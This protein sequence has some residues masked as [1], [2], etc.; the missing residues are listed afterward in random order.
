MDKSF[1]VPYN[2]L[3]TSQELQL[4]LKFRPVSEA[5]ISVTNSEIHVYS[6]ILA[7]YLYSK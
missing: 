2:E 5:R 6:N 1:V 4:S 7:R 3:I